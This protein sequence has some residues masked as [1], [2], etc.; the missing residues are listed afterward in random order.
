[1]MLK[2]L[3]AFLAG[4]AIAVPL[5]FWLLKKVRIKSKVRHFQVSLALGLPTALFIYLLQTSFALPIV[6]ITVA[7]SLLVVALELTLRRLVSSVPSASA[8]TFG[9]YR[10]GASV[11]IDEA[12]SASGYYPY[13]YFTEDFST[14]LHEFAQ[15]RSKH[16]DAYIQLNGQ[17]P[18]QK[19]YLAYKNLSFEGKFCSMTNGIRHTTDKHSSSYEKRVFILGA[20]TVFGIEV[21]DKLTVASFLQRMINLT[22][23]PVEVLN[24][25]WSGATVVDR[26][27]MLTETVDVKQ[28]DV[29]VFYFGGADAGWLDHRSGKLS[30]QLIPI[31][32][33]AL[34]GLSDFGV[35][36]ARWLYLELS[37]R[38]F[39]KYSRMAVADTIKT[40]GEVHEYCIRRGA[41]MIAILQPN[42]YTLRTKSVY[43]KTLEKRFSR[44]MKTLI[45]GAYK[46][47]EDW[48]KVNPFAVSATHIFND[49]PGSVFLDWA[50]ANAL[51]SELIA[52]FIY[53]EL[54][55]RKLIS[56]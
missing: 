5:T 13:D 15:S 1:M 26:S 35:E 44:D 29:F 14:E 31:P 52:E 53:N 8:R 55:S 9:M 40:L 25:G 54:S 17:V 47:Y 42:I 51:G 6:I 46:N 50:H 7:F 45:L 2:V 27:R 33:R 38:S 3:A 23:K 12:R 36:T 48:V 11:P 37:P 4:F 20:S 30:Q 28:N 43:E 18:S 49:S 41:H 16:L 21:P 39:R 32:I 10:I 19:S 24:Y 56:D 22:T 34:R